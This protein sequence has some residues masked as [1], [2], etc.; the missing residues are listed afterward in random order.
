MNE[1]RG[2]RIPEAAVHLSSHF[3]NRLQAETGVMVQNPQFISL[4]RAM[5]LTSDEFYKWIGR[6]HMIFNEKVTH[7]QMFGMTGSRFW[8]AR[9]RRMR[10]IDSPNSPR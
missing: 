9:S 2:L 7:G 3:K 6:M 10:S 8:R 1:A 4:K 5:A